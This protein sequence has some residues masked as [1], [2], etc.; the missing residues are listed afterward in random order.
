MALYKKPTCI[1]CI[2]ISN[3]NDWYYIKNA[4]ESIGYRYENCNIN[5]TIIDNCLLVLNCGGV[6][7]KISNFLA[8]IEFV[9]NYDRYLV[10]DKNDFINIATNLI[11][12][13]MEK[14]NI[15]IDL[16]TAK[17][18]YNGDDKT[19]KELALQAYDECELNDI[20]Y[21]YNY[22]SE[23]LF[24][25]KQ[26][27]YIGIQGGIRKIEKVNGFAYQDPNNCTSSK[28][29]EKLLAINKLLNVAKYLNDGWIPNW[30]DMQESKYYIRIINNNIDVACVCAICLGVVYFK[31]EDLAKQAIEIL[32]K[33]NIKM[34][35]SADY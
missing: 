8:N 3:I 34:A 27:Y 30:D 7:G 2:K 26:T 28:Q 10:N 15:Q 4:L 12:N 35:L 23:K 33:E 22:I 24:N 19:L 29:C 11:K 32:G 5:D 14:R 6:F 20:D 1:P 25:E 18:W 9:R 13:N 31:T 21:N 16:K 17:Q